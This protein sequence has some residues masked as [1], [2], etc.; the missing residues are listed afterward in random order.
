VIYDTDDTSP[1]VFDIDWT[2]VK[3]QILASVPTA[4]QVEESDEN[5]LFLVYDLNDVTAQW[6]D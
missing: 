4:R 1:S 2:D 5:T 3:L 6:G